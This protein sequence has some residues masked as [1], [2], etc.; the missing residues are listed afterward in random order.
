MATEQWCSERVYTS[1][2]DHLCPRKGKV[3]RNGKWYCGQHDPEAVAAKQAAKDRALGVR[4]AAGKAFYARRELELNVLKPYSTE[5]LQG[6][7]IAELVAAAHAVQAER[8]AGRHGN[9]G[10]ILDTGILRRALAKLEGKEVEQ[11]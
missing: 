1:F 3:E 10:L 6:G 4:W 7:A 8:D 5:A 2:H 9:V 11:Q